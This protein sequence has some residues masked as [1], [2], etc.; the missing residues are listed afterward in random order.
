MASLMDDLVLVLESEVEQYKKLVALS[1]AMRDALVISDVSA[2]EQITADQESV[3][4]DLQALEGQRVRIMNDMALVLNRKPEELKVSALEES[5]GHQPQLQERL[6]N[7][8]MELTK[9]MEELKRRN[10]SNQ[11]LLRQSMELLEFDLNLFRSM[12]QAP[13]TAN[14]NKSA[15]NTGDLLGSRGFDAKQ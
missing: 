4:N 3:A 14:Y 2:V 1:E 13:E 15:Y 6:R 7:V 10:Q 8:R 9:T 11:A 12:R 5:I